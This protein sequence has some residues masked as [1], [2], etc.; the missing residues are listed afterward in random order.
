MGR[1]KY[2][3]PYTRSGSS[4]LASLFTQMLQRNSGKDPHFWRDV[5]IT[6]IIIAILMMWANHHYYGYWFSSMYF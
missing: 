3:I 4:I 6:M 2:Y 5:V 1:R